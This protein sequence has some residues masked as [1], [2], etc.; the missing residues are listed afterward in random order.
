MGTDNNGLLGQQRGPLPLRKRSLRHHPHVFDGWVVSSDTARIPAQHQLKIGQFS[1]SVQDLVVPVSG[2]PLTVV[3]TYNSFNLNQG[4]FGY[5][6]TYAINDVNLEID[7]FREKRRID[8]AE[9][10]FSL[11]VG[12]GRDVTLTLPDGNRTTFSLLFRWAT[13]LQWRSRCGHT[14]TWP[15]D[16]TA[17]RRGLTERHRS[18]PTNNGL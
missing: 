11:R 5:G 16:G 3:R 4:D 7:E 14:A 13:L 1:F 15:M 12:G 18:T 10:R 9:G 8:S 6:W 17:R 2:M